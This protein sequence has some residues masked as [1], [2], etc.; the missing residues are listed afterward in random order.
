MYP[1]LFGYWHFAISKFLWKS[2]LKV[3]FSRIHESTNHQLI[4]SYWNF[5]GLWDVMWWI[6]FMV[7]DTLLTLNQED[8]CKCLIFV[9]LLYD[10]YIS[11]MEVEGDLVLIAIFIFCKCWSSCESLSNAEIPLKQFRTV[12]IMPQWYHM[13]NIIKSIWKTVPKCANYIFIIL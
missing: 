9:L 5:R 7:G 2:K 6:L 8:I 10:Y 1:C 13:L 4:V 3:V 11:I 12:P